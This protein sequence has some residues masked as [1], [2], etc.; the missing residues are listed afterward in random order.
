MYK[1]QVIAQ[2]VLKEIRDEMFTGMQSLP[3]RYFDTHQSGDTMSRYTNDTDTLRQM[4]AQSMPQMFSSVITIV[5]VFCAMV[6]TSIYLTLV[7]LAVV[8]VMFIV[9]RKIAGKSLSLIHICVL[10][11]CCIGL[12]AIFLW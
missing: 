3:I 7:V 6:A 9:S 8:A 10:Y 11:R 12:T 1:R 4:I 5:A 2:G